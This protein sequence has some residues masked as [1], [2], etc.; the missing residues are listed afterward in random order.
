MTILSSP[1]LAYHILRIFVEEKNS[2]NWNEKLLSLEE[3][4]NSLEKLLKTSFKGPKYS[5]FKESVDW[6]VEKQFLKQ[7]KEGN[8]KFF[9]LLNAGKEFYLH[10]RYIKLPKYLIFL[11]NPLV[12]VG[13]FLFHDWPFLLFA[14]LF[15]R[16]T[17]YFT[18]PGFFVLLEFMLFLPILGKW[19]LNPLLV[20][21]YGLD[22][23]KN[24]MDLYN[25]IPTYLINLGYDIRKL[26]HNSFLWS[27]IL[28]FIIN[29]ILAYMPVIDLGLSA[30][31]QYGIPINYSLI[32]LIFNLVLFPL[33]NFVF[34]TT[35]FML[36][37]TGVFL[38]SIPL[39][40]PEEVL[41]KNI[42]SNIELHKRV[43]YVTIFILLNA[44]YLA[45]IHALP[46][47]P[48]PF[49]SV[50]FILVIIVIL[51]TSMVLF[52][53]LLGYQRMQKIRESFLQKE[54]KL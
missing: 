13:I 17:S 25:P 34:F 5:K 39:E 1:E 30:P 22:L 7:R 38:N 23:V 18:F 10:G 35:M 36:V 15:H 26:M 2:N 3:L 6:L 32:T 19:Y 44:L 40:V 50:F 49:Y 4:L 28:S 42:D 43:F 47:S 24:R 51:T 20:E 52:I 16:L 27:M 46:S 45:A 9:E 8:A 37:F 31:G 54:K 29:F 33:S 11:V 53:W 12:Y 48:Y 14:T 21:A 41:A